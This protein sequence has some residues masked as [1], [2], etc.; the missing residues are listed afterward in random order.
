MLKAN[1]QYFNS[2]P[3]LTDNEYDILKDILKI[4]FLTQ[5]LKLEQNFHRI[6]PMM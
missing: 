4:V 3:V 5:N 2:Q 6:F 1:Q